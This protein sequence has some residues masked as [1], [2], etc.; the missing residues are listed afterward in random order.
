MTFEQVESKIMALSQGSGQRQRHG[1][2]FEPL[3]KWWLRNDPAWSSLFEEVWLWKEWP[4]RWKE[5]EAGIDHVAR[6]ANGR[7]MW[8]IQVKM[9]YQDTKVT[10][11]AIQAFVSESEG[12]DRRLLITT[13]WDLSFH[14]RDLCGRLGIVVV[15]RENLLESTVEWPATWPGAV[16]AARPRP[17]KSKKVKPLDEEVQDAVEG[18]AQSPMLGRRLRAT[19][20]K[21][22]LTQDRLAEEASLS[23]STIH[24]LE[25]GRGNLSSWQKVL[26][27]LSLSVDGSNLPP[28]ETIGQ[29]V[30]RLRKMRRISQRKLATLAQSTPPTIVA[31]ERRN[32]GRLDLLEKVLI[33]LGAGHYI[34]EEDD[35][36][37]LSIA[38]SPDITSD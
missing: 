21:R 3:V 22:H 8:A 38:L 37:L 11:Q 2:M 24:L 19:R 35:F 9:W 15:A 32:Q 4:D 13:S 12:F 6:G 20:K 7:E 31:L 33:I 34:A 14:A 36:S 25:S 10:K 27:A 17:R 5:Q 1:K 26:S 16:E 30:V 29:R 28:G 18:H 23:V